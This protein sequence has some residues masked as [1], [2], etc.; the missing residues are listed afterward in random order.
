[1]SPRSPLLDLDDVTDRLPSFG[2]TYLGLRQ[3]PVDRVIGT[4]DR[5]GAF[6]A[7]FRPLLPASQARLDSLARAFADGAFPPINVIEFGG[8]YFVVDGHHRVRL[9]RQRG[10][11]VIDG[12][13]T[14]VWSRYE[15]PPDVDVPALI[16][17][18]QRLAFLTAAGLGEARADGDLIFSR[19]QGYPELLEIVRAFAYA[20]SL[21]AGRLVRAGV[22]SA[23]WYD[24]DYRPGV[25]ALRREGL[26]EIYSYKTDT[27]LWLWVHQL[28]RQLIGTG[29]EGDHGAAARLAARTRVAR[30]FRRRFLRQRSVPL[31][32]TPRP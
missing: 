15:L 16:H 11:E 27:D 32:P 1:M 13:V 14:R 30:S 24:R 21:R 25:A 8:G 31:T 23:R 10:M 19:V 17:T 18:Q 4:M 26:H 29:E 7:D 2:R 3:V 22:A 9:A 20:E 5:S 12:E 28:Q 6:D